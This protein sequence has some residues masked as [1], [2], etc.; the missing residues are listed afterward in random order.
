MSYSAEATFKTKAG[1]IFPGFLCKQVA[2]MR[3]KLFSDYGLSPVQVVEAASFSMA[4]VVRYALGLTADGGKTSIIANDTLSG[5]VALATLR[6]LIN[7]GAA[8]RVIL[9]SDPASAGSENLQVQ[10]RP[11]QRLGAEVL[12][13]AGLD[14]QPV[15]E[16]THN[17]ILG[18]F[19]PET[20]QNH[21]MADLIDA[22]NEHQVPIHCIE[23]PPGIQPDSGKAGP[24]PLYAS[25][26]LSLGAPLEGLFGGSDYVGRHYLCDISISSELYAEAGFDL[27]GLFAE[28][29]VIQ[30]YPGKEG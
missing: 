14:L 11:L 25:S 26:T 15:M 22:L 5:W 17:L 13:L 29:P 12:H 30:I 28:Q 8:G 9:T 3:E 19:D 27:C 23:A 1:L 4:M 16:N 7:A 2:E 21:Q 18:T 24:C 20:N 6:H 10:L